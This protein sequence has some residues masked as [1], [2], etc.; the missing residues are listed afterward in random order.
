LSE[1]TYWHYVKVQVVSGITV[2]VWQYVE[3]DGTMPAS[4]VP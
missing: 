3:Y 4:F 2:Y 1:F